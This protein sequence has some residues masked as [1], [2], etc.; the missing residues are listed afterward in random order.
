MVKNPPANAKNAGDS[1]LILG[2]GRAPWGGNGNPLLIFLP[3]KFHRQRSLVHGVARSQTWLSNWAWSQMLKSGPEF[4]FLFVKKFQ[5]F[6]NSIQETLKSSTTLWN[7]E[8]I[9][10]KK[11]R[12]LLKYGSKSKYF[13]SLMVLIYFNTN[14]HRYGI[15]GSDFNFWSSLEYMVLK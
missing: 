6:P 5:H 15:N 8:G 1:G 13:E 2:S 9:K 7:S 11:K 12:K 14:S 3:G 10:E 4:S